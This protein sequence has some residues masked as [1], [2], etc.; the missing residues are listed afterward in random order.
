MILYICPYIYDILE[1]AK[2]QKWRT[3]KGFQGARG[4]KGEVGMAVKGQ[5]E[6]FLW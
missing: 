3:D 1:M 4:E 6:G 5:H 2:L